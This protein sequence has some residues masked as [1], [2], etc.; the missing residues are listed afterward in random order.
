MSSKALAVGSVIDTGAPAK[1]ALEDES[2]DTGVEIIKKIDITG[3]NIT[4]TADGQGNVN[5]N[6]QTQTTV[7]EINGGNF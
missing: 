2:T 1:I 4:A 3:D 6:V 7:D 5:I